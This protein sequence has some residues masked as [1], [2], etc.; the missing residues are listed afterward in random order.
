MFWIH[1]N[2][3][4]N[5]QYEQWM[6]SIFCLPKYSPLV[7]LHGNIPQQHFH[8]LYCSLKFHFQ[9]IVSMN[10]VTALTAV[11]LTQKWPHR[12]HSNN[13]FSQWSQSL[14]VACI[15]LTPPMVC[16][17]TQGPESGNTLTLTWIYYDQLTVSTGHFHS[18]ALFCA[19][20]VMADLT[21]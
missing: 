11:H 1:K 17:I 21:L 12:W 2:F 3:I 16:V 4:D 10:I 19:V 7:N 5:L 14:M 6:K 15:W 8:F 13:K 9:N 20:F 18:L